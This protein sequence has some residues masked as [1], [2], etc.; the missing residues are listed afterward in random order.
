VPGNMSDAQ[1]KFLTD[2]F[3]DCRN[4]LMF[5]VAN[6]LNSNLH[7]EDIVQETYIRLIRTNC[8]SDVAFPRALIYRIAY[9]LA[10][11]HLRWTIRNQTVPL[12]FEYGSSRESDDPCPEESLLADE[13]IRI[14]RDA[15]LSLPKRCQQVY[16][17][18]KLYDLPHRDIALQLGISVRTVENHIAA[19]TRQCREYLVR[20]ECAA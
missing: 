2:A 18:G 4:A 17:L 13:Q 5:Y 1:R 8:E 12:S 19:A 16:T 20:H 14:V 7:A 3:V 9:N 15:I 6:L 11:D 10:L